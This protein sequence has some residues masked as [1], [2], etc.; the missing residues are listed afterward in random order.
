[1]TAYIDLRGAFAAPAYWAP[2]EE[3]PPAPAPPAPSPDDDS[4]PPAGVAGEGEPV[5]GEAPENP[6]LKKLHDEAARHRVRAKDAEAKAEGLAAQVRSLTL[7]IAFNTLAGEAE[8]TDLDAA[9]KLAA[10]DLTVVDVA[11]DGT[12]DTERLAQIVAHVAERY[13]Y[14]A[15]APAPAT[16]AKADAFPPTEPSGRPTNGRKKQIGGLNVE[17]LESKFPALRHKRR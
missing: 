16:P 1:M 2:P 9:W 10:D 4:A 7:R 15:S 5:E 17:L 3:D 14:L 12:V 11:E 8:L 13:P 6:E